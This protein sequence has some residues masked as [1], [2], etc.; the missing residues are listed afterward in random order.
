MKKYTNKQL[1]LNKDKRYWDAFYSV[2]KDW[3][4]TT[5]HKLTKKMPLIGFIRGSLY[6]NHITGFT[7]VDSDFYTK[8]KD[9]PFTRWRYVSL[10]RN[11]RVYRKITGYNTEFGRDKTK[12]YLL[13]HMVRGHTNFSVYVVDH[14]NGI[15]LDNRFRNLR[16]ATLAENTYNMSKS[17]TRSKVSNYKGVFYNKS[18]R[19]KK[20]RAKFLTSTDSSIPNYLRYKT[21]Y[22]HTEEEAARCYD[23]H[24]IKLFGE[25]AKT[26]F[27]Y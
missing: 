7:Y 11:Q 21:K 24:A 5:H 10:S 17:K 20:W 14:K 15:I 23:E 27:K 25:F 9:Y 18:D 4:A 8:W 16:T 1:I 13:H 26:N 12:A 2:I 6:P 3:D 19:N 22:F